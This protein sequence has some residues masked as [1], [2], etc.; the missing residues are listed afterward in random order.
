MALAVLLQ[1]VLKKSELKMLCGQTFKMIKP[2]EL[3][4][5]NE[6]KKKAEFCGRLIYSKGKSILLCNIN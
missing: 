1:E 6:R 5:S 3:F 2:P 4:F